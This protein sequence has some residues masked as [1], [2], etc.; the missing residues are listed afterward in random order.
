MYRGRYQTPPL[1]WIYSTAQFPIVQYLHLRCRNMAAGC[2]EKPVTAYI[3][4]LKTTAKSFM[5]TLE[6]N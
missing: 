4:R 5:H 6:F 1:N 2:G 3:P